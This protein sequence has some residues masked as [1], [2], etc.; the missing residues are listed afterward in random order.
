MSKR[1][2]LVGAASAALISAAMVIAPLGTAVAAPTPLPER[3]PSA[4][5]DPSGPFAADRP[6][7]DE[8]IDQQQAAG[9]KLYEPEGE[10]G[11]HPIDS[12]GSTD[13]A[14]DKLGEADTR[15]LQQAQSDEAETV[16]VMMLARDGADEEIIAAV[17]Q[18][19]GVVGSTTEELG[20][21]RATVPTDAVATLAAMPS[22]KAI[23]LNRT[24]QV[25]A[26]DRGAGVTASPFAL[27]AGPSAPDASTP[28]AN[29]YMP[30]DETGALSFLTANP[31]WD[32]RGTVVG[33]VD[34]GVDLGHPAL[35]TTSDGKPKIIDWVTATDPI[36]DRDGTWVE[37]ATAKSGPAFRFA[38]YEWTAPAGEFLI[39][40][41]YEY[42]TMGAE[43]SGDL[44]GNGTK[45]DAFGVLYE[46]STHTIWVDADNDKDFTN[47]PAMAPFGIDQQL[48]HFGADDPATAQNEQIPFVVEYR[49]G[50]DMAPAGGEAGTTGTFVNIGIPSGAHGTHVAG[51]VA[52]T[53]MFGGEMHGAAPGA[54][55]VSSRACTFAGGCT[56]AAL[57]EGMIDLVVNRDVDVVN[58]SI[59][60]LPPLNDG[61]DVIADL[62]DQ[63]IEQYGVQIV[64]A[65]G[66]DGLGTN[67]VG[68]PSVAAEVISVAASVS[69]STWW[70]NYGSQVS[71]DEGIFGFSSRGP[72]ENGGL[73]PQVAAP[74][75]A[76]SPIPMWLPGQAVLETGY[77]LPAGYGMFNGTSMAAPQV[78]GSAALLLSAAKASKVTVSASALKTALIGT[79]SLIPGIPTTAQ[80]AGVID[81]VAAW[82]TL[83]K[84]VSV[85]ELEIAAPVCTSLS[86]MLDT[87]HVGA[88]VYNRCLPEAGGQVTGQEKT[89]GIQ[90]TRTS[91]SDKSIGHKIGWIGNDGTFSAR[92]SLPLKKDKASGVTV[93][94]DA[95][96]SGLHSA[97][98]TIDDPATPGIDQFVGVTV[99]ATA[100]LTGPDFAV[101]DSG[102]LPRGGSTSVL[103]PVPAGVEALQLTLDG[104]V[105]GSQMRILPVDPDGMPA[106]SNASNHC[107]TDYA[108]PA[109]CDATARAIY[110]PKPGVWE[111]VIEARRTSGTDANAYSAS[112][113]LQGLTVAPVSTTIDS[114]TMHE[115]TDVSMTG[116]NAF[117]AVEAHVATGEIG[118]V[119]NLFATVAQG[120]QIA[121]MLYI[122]RESTRLDVTLTARESADLDFYVFFGGRPIGQSA[123]TGVGAERIV[124]DDPQPG[125]YYIVVAGVSV[126]GEGVTFDYHQ[127]LFSKGQGTVT[128]T[129]DATYS[130]APGETMPVEGA[131]TVSA[132]QLTTEAM[133]GRV[134]VANEHGT[135]I[136]A[137]S[138]AIK[139]VEVPQLD[140]VGW[141]GPFVG[142][143]MTDGGVVAGDRQY[144]ERMTPTTWSAENG[145]VNLHM[146]D[147]RHGMALGINEDQTAVGILT[148]S[149]WGYQPSMWTADGALTVIG[150]PDWRAYPGGYATAIND[151][152]IVTGFAELMEQGEDGMWHSYSDP[153]TRTPDGVF[154]K[155]EQLSDDPSGTQTRAINA[156]GTVV[157]Y[158]NTA[159]YAPNAVTWDAATGAVRNLGTLPGQ[160]MAMGLDV[161]ASGTVVGTSGDDAFVWTETGGMTRLADYGYNA[162]AEKVTDDGWV[163]GTVE[164]APD[165]AVSSLWDP[166]GRLWDLSGMVPVENGGWFLP[167]YS[168]D[169][170]NEH[171]LMLYGEGGANG[172]DS[173]S[174]MLSIPASMRD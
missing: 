60:G 153:F 48:S 91:G 45:W 123:T 110:R 165:F 63:L 58:L 79:A 109:E 25:P 30:I 122:P 89:Y 90:V 37:M 34:T 118:T 44:D 127:E 56:Q 53:S 97:I 146:G 126:P 171:Q 10:A 134:R 76:V 12:I 145:F 106:D 39:G 164:L 138:V 119:T 28:A 8:A 149:F 161:N 72:A 159:E 147:S 156:A 69:S 62:Y 160:Y 174:V 64:V 22:V 42:Y 24:F 95:A 78:A 107:Y 114:V 54:Q 2:K 155:L 141:A 73:A 15:L 23:D 65:A 21:V 80:G 111:F 116:T 55:I 71:T 43:L 68:S 13:D 61:S 67:T 9:D 142:A 70:A 163:L 75:S 17:H 83:A 108:D 166:Q 148:D 103:V 20:Y 16:T 92:G 6:L 33:V 154:H 113:A 46:P 88:G 102:V 131:L 158:A 167:L 52:A 168:F 84:K 29:P 32:G 105:D 139:A 135:I 172:S 157:G 169:I 162:T 59:G 150:V 19:G 51:I 128:P 38:G 81:T 31:E 93:T 87:P 86:G 125:T 35:Q 99:L 5:P 101:T 94:A 140:V 143:E 47:Q 170:N 104:I 117:G 133:V 173:S 41:F 1:K 98:M 152:G 115:P 27:G 82:K 129:S 74:G 14:T 120:E 112:V 121:N 11:F 57:T 100:P 85:N 40:N 77:D 144:E 96:T 130:L 132:R 49:E 66:N 18:A 124:I 137:A 36:Q 151:D 4:A 50:V 136:G 7:A 26:P 3:D